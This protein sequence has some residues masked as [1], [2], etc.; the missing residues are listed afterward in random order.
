M[1]TTSP[2][3]ALPLCR[4]A[5]WAPSEGAS[6]AIARMVENKYRCIFINSIFPPFLGRRVS[7][8]LGNSPRVISMIQEGYSP[9]A[10]LARSIEEQ[11]RRILAS[12]PFVQSARMSRFLRFTV[13]RALAGQSDRLKEY[14]IGVEVF[15]RKGSYDPR[16][17]PIVRVEARR[18]RS[19]LKTYYEADGRADD[20][21]IE[22]PKGA[23][24]PQIRSKQSGAGDALGRN[25]PGGMAVLPFT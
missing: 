22:F 4:L 8:T 17:D 18:L 5:S 14:V 2:T 7:G 21:V 9:V 16:V 13:E 10:L 12:K 20:I 11:L 25:L 1:E 15:D 19:K 24:A 3:V 6:S 23:Y